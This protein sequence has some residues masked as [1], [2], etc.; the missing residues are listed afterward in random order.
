MEGEHVKLG[1]RAILL[2]AEKMREREGNE[3]GTK[4]EHGKT[5]R[6][7][8]WHSILLRAKIEGNEKGTGVE[9]GNNM[10]ANLGGVQYL[11]LY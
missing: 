4:W 10:E 9:H 3:K 2:R 11:L 5:S 7:H 6:K 1:W 8:G